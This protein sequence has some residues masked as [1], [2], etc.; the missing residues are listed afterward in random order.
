MYKLCVTSEIVT[1]VT[2]DKEHVS[3]LGWNF[4][5]TYPLR[6]FVNVCGSMVVVEYHD[7]QDDRGG[8]HEHDAVEVR[9]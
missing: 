6:H 8:H 7:S 2:I 9:P 5:G 4:T 3:A 1:N